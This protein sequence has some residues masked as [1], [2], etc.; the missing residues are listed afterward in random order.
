MRHPG[1]ETNSA[2]RSAP[3]S[4]LRRRCVTERGRRHFGR[5]QNRPDWR[6][7][8]PALTPY[9]IGAFGLWVMFV[10]PNDFAVGFHACCVSAAMVSIRR[11]PMLFPGVLIDPRDLQPPFRISF[12]RCDEVKVFGVCSSRMPERF[13]VTSEEK[14]EGLDLVAVAFL[15][16]QISQRSHHS[17]A[18]HGDATH[19]REMLEAQFLRCQAMRSP[20]DVQ[21]HLRSPGAVIA[22]K[23]RRV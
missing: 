8:N 7:F 14:I 23:V 15:L 21:P 18:A 3:F 5:H 9:S 6:C 10:L 20:D 19:S 17:W 12:V 13:R 1:Q 2:H 4:G 16:I 11:D 22:L